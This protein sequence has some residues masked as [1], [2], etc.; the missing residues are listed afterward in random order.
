VKRP[1]LAGL[2][3]CVAAT[4][5]C[6]EKRFDAPDRAERVEE[7][8]ALY[9]PAMFDTIAWASAEE[10]LFVG[11]DVFG[12]HCRRCHG[13]FGEGDTPYARERGIEVPS[14]VEP[15]WEY[16]G[17]LDAVR[18]RIFAGHPAGMPVWGFGGTTLR[19]I[20]AVAYYILEQLRP[21]LLG[22]GAG[23]ADRQP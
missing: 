19:E 18:R 5:A 14:L 2:L 13:P 7:A 20:D 8:E 23:D 9:S 21:E 12:A 15:E 16:E 1:L 22:A 17:D 10:R 6:E 11:N 4:A 3:A